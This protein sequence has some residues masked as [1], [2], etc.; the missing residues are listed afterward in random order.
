MQPELEVWENFGLLLVL[1]GI[2]YCFL[3]WFPKYELPMSFLTHVYLNTLVMLRVQLPWIL[4]VI[5]AL[6]F[7]PFT[8]VL[9]VYLSLILQQIPWTCALNLA[10]VFSIAT[11]VIE[12]CIHKMCKSYTNGKSILIGLSKSPPPGY[13]LIKFDETLV[14]QS[15][16]IFGVFLHV[17]TKEDE[18]L[19]PPNEQ[20][21]K[22][23]ESTN[24]SDESTNESDESTSESDEEATKSNES[25]QTTE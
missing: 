10:I 7:I 25:T 22:T 4:F 20:V 5:V 13:N 12:A 16:N 14:P 19:L 15:H 8:F 23:N 6:Q 1:G 18:S 3:Q 21:T 11:F 2:N 9:S 24:E 17:I